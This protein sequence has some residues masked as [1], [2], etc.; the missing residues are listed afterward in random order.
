[1]TVNA[2]KEQNS[3]NKLD[4]WLMIFTYLCEDTM[5]SCHSKLTKFANTPCC[6]HR[7]LWSW[8]IQWIWE[9]MR[10]LLMALVDSLAVKCMK[11]NQKQCI[12]LCCL[13]LNHVQQGGETKSLGTMA[14]H[15]PTTPS[16]DGVVWQLWL[17]STWRYCVSHHFEEVG[18]TIKNLETV[19]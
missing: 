4:Y 17:L 19:T 16:P 12:S 13:L 1:M 15:R 2:P 6:K 18:R 14:Y 5:I 11:R 10:L 3:H 9:C 7:W 8:P